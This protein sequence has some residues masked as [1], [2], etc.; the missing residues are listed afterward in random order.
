MK[1]NTHKIITALKK[2]LIS[3]RKL[4]KKKNLTFWVDPKTAEKAS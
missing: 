4:L 1:T 2:R 3:I